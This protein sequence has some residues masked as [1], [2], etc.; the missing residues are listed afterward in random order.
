[1]DRQTFG[2][3]DKWTDRQMHRETDEQMDIEI[4][5][6]MDRHKA[7]DL[8][9][10]KSWNSLGPTKVEKDGDGGGDGNNYRI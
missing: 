9:D 4:D 5:S 6:Q 1:M 10:S 8:L 3:T 2:Q 7:K